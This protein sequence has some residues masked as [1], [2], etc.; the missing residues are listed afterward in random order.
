MEKEWKGLRD[1]GVWR[2]CDVREL[3]D[4]IQDARR[5]GSHVEFGRV[6]GICVEKSCEL[7]TGHPNGKR[8]GRAVFLGSQVVNQAFDRAVFADYG[9]AP[10]TLEIERLTD[11]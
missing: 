3:S 7:P 2:E 6:H 4:V 10:S 11:F 8:K 9:N 1:K 5:A